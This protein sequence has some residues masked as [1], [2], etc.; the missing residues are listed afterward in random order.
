[1]DSFF[2]FFGSIF[3]YVLWWFYLLIPNYGVAIILFTVLFKVLLFP[4]S[5][6]Q[7]KSM[8]ASGKMQVKME[9]LKKRYANDKQR[10]QV[11]T[12]KLYEK[13]GVDPTGGCSTM[14]LPFLIM[15][16]I[17]YTVLNPLSNALH[18][19]SDAISQA[20][21]MLGQI[22]GYSSISAGR[23]A[24][25][26]IVRNFTDLKP[27]LTMFSADEIGRLQSFS[28]G[29]RFLGLDLL[30]TPSDGANLFGTLF[31]TNLWII[32]VLCLVSSLVTQYFTLKMQPGMQNQQQGCM[33]YG[34]YG[35]ALFSAW[36]ACTVP[37]AVGFYWVISTVTAFIQTL[38]M[39]HF[40]SP[41]RMNAEAEAA[42]A[43]LREQQ[44]A[45]AKPIGLPMKK[46][47][48]NGK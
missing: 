31:Q 8:A 18:L 43:A 26:E 37:A 33:K 20:V 15:F 7:Q 29:F 27:F 12:Q 16:G 22:P 2:N 48:K 19:S 23:Y 38:V 34:F 1:M 41:D 11:E 45:A 24:Q 39:N 47:R 32:P 17:Y 5:I 40:Y 14:F 28:N 10:L 46:E 3:G 44:E 21:A 4:F 25:I 9:A 36:L 30:G 35:M 6:K 13:E 42:R